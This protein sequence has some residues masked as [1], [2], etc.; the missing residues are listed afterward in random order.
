MRAPALIVRGSRGLI[1][2]NTGSR[3]SSFGDIAAFGWVVRIAFFP[4][5]MITGIAMWRQAK[6]RKLLTKGWRG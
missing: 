6:L 3:K 1:Y 2:P 5:A 4:L